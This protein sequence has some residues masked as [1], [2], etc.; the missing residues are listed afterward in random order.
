MR[1]GAGRWRLTV[2]LVAGVLSLWAQGLIVC[3][4]CGREAKAGDT[5]CRHCQ[6]PLPEPRNDAPPAAESEVLPDAESDVR[7]MAAGR[8][9]ACVRQARDAEV[10]Q[11]ELALCYYQ[12]ALALMRLVPAGTFPD[13]VNGA[14]L[15][16][17]TR[18]LQSLQRGTVP[19]RRCGGSG[20]Y[21]MDL[22]KVDRGKGLKAVDG[23]PC[24][25]CKGGG[26]LAGF[27]DVTKAKMLVV[28]GRSEFDR[29]QMVA[30]DVRV[31]RVWVSPDLD[32][33][34]T[35]RQRALI[36]TGMPTPCRECRLT[37]RQT[38]AACRGS[39]WKPCDGE[40]CDHGILKETRR[41]GSRKEKRMNE[42]SAKKCPRCGGSGE[43]PCSICKGAGS[44]ACSTC[45][46]SG[47]A[48]RCARCT[49][50]GILSCSKCKGTG[51]VKGDTCPACKGENMTLCPTC[52]GEG[53]LAR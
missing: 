30:G 9:E 23:V 45:D 50:T 12:N 37:G 22:G 43:C 19:C 8:V 31:G 47:L 44:V 1:A 18:A 3:G 24:P 52:R 53:A 39:G 40:G 6:A 21:Q 14:I 17:S 11:P 42:E 41:A 27:R 7:R 26:S 49:G 28:Q 36:M 48:P 25:V 51:T 32:R 29:R 15:E 20:R 2:C 4:R 16:G 46:G 35:N 13:G 38:C 34:L 33:V 10:K 5:V